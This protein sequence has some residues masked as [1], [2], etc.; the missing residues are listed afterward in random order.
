[1]TIAS[2]RRTEAVD[3]WGR[4]L[5][6]RFEIE[7]SGPPLLYLHPA[8]GMLW[9]AFLYRLAERFTIYAPILPGTDL[10]DTMAIH[11]LDDIHELVLAYEGALRSLGIGDAPVIGQSFGGMLAAEL[12]VTFPGLF[13]RVVLLAP[14]GLWDKSA[15]WDLDFMTAPPD[16]LPGLL[17][18]DPECEGA[19]SI[20]RPPD[21]PE[22]ALDNAVRSIWTLG[23]VA[24]FLWP[25]PDRG[26][27]RRLHR[28]I[29]PTLIIWGQDDALIPVSYAQAYR[30][31]I[32]H[33]R[34]EIIPDC[35][36]IPQLE[37][38]EITAR[39]V[40]EFLK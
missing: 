38:T 9:D 32:P 24:K 19:Q 2:Q 15:P 7:G 22:Q 31:L 10:A 40:D 14:L 6:L 37:K 18:K 11:Q 12:A 1:M 39:F 21:S 23:C 16:A 29:D 33:S 27:S 35:G 17:F 8:G 26:L 4:R 34:I 5:T 36:H 13:S 20:F 30:Q 3:A 25:V 28:L